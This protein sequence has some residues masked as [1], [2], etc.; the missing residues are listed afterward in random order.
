[1]KAFFIRSRHIASRPL[2]CACLLGHAQIFPCSRRLCAVSGGA[3]LEPPSL[4]L[5]PFA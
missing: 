5:P 3:A 4:S 2:L 1:M